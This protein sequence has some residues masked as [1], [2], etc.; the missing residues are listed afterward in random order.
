MAKFHAHGHRFLVSGK[1][2]TI[3]VFITLFLFLH[4]CVEKNDLISLSGLEKVASFLVHVGRFGAVLSNT[5][6][7][8]HM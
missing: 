6:V 3:P 7:T 4:I 2:K 8:S 1:I 5:M